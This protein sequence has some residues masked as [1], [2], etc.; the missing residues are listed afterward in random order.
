[1]SQ[2]TGLRHDRASKTL[3]PIILPDASRSARA[4]IR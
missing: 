1:M 3:E 4:N 2:V